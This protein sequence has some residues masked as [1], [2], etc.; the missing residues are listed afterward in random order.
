MVVKDMAR[1]VIDSLPDEATMEEIIDALYIRT[2]FEHGE[3]EI[4]D[5]KGIPH[6]QAKE[7]LKKWLK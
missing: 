5:G 2:K 4:R 3:Q 1:S 7:R 6:E